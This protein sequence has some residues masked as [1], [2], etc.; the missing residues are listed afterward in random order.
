MSEGRINLDVRDLRGWRGFAEI[1]RCFADLILRLAGSEDP[2]LFLAAA[3]AS[4]AVQQ[5]HI[6]LNLGEI[7]GTDLRAGAPGA[8]VSDGDRLTLPPLD[9]WLA[10]LGASGAS[11]VVSACGRTPLILAS[12]GRLYLH[13]YWQLEQRLARDLRALAGPRSEAPFPA[14]DL[15]ERLG[16][17]F[18]EPA[19]A[20]I[21]WQK[22]AAFAALRNRLTIISGGP[23]TGKTYTVARILLLSLEQMRRERPGQTPRIRLAAPTGKAAARLRESI[24]TAKAQPGL[25]AH[26]DRDLIPARA[27]TLHRLLGSI[28]GRTAFRHN[29][30]NPLPADMVVIDEASMVAL[31]LMARVTAAL[32]DHARLVLLGDR[33]QL[34]SVE[35]GYVLGDICEA[36]EMDR[37]SPRFAREL[38]DAA[39]ERIPPACVG[40]QSSLR[41]CA[42]NLVHSRRFP[43]S[44]SVGRISRA[45]NQAKDEAGA[46]TAL[47]LLEELA[48][49]GAGTITFRPTPPRLLDAAGR[50][51]QVLRDQL[52]AGFAPFLNAREPDDALRA[53]ARFRVLCAVRNGPHGVEELN[54]VAERVLSL[55]GVRDRSA[56]ARRLG[57]RPLHIDGPFYDHRPILVREN[58]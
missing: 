55:R 43:P 49:P 47:S 35:P 22:V 8:H 27:V 32:P 10:C 40:G 15:A 16:V 50:P 9:A 21:D 56:T 42:V 4:R 26:P 17:L 58:D 31:P 18:P 33:N 36:A 12:G 39:G 57:F 34:A 54:R 28:P 14:G 1:D 7:A 13:R 53:L 45:I 41:D 11:S 24:L 48:R 37:F 46:A 3:L 5:G 44:S 52:T 2:P 6:C 29:R 23:G 19:A 30:D 51:L 20:G 25:A 38:V